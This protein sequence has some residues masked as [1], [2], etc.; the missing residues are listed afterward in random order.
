MWQYGDNRKSNKS[1]DN[2]P[3]LTCKN[4]KN[5]KMPFHPGSHVEEQEIA[6]GHKTQETKYIRQQ[7]QVIKVAIVIDIIAKRNN[8]DE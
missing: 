8:R 4:Y 2:N 7:A 1:N 5:I 6:P 3:Y